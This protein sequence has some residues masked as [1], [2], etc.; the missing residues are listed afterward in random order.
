METLAHGV[1]GLA[2]AWKV[3]RTGGNFD[4][5]ATYFCLA[6][7]CGNQ[8]FRISCAEPSAACAKVST[9]YFNGETA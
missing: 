6:V 7:S 4:R 3:Q 9:V 2:H 5:T 1:E 8:S